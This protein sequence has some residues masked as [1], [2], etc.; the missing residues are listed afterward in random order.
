MKLFC[1]FVLCIDDSKWPDFTKTLM[2]ELQLNKIQLEAGNIL[3]ICSYETCMKY[4][5][6]N[7]PSIDSRYAAGRY[8]QRFGQET[9]GAEL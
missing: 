7:D 5:Y 2:R 4:H 3:V 9:D 6:T 8:A 1:V